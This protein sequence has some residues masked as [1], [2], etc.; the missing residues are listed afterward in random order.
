MAAAPQEAYQVKAVMLLS[1]VLDRLASMVNVR[2]RELVNFAPAIRN[3]QQTTA[4][5]DRVSRATSAGLA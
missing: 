4:A 2:Y 5:T 1:D 3:A